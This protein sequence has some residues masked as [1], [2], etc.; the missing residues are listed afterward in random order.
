MLGKF[1]HLLVCSL[2]VLSSHFYCASAW[3]CAVIKCEILSFPSCH[4]LCSSQDSMLQLS[5]AVRLCALVKR[6]KCSFGSLQF[7]NSMAL[8]LSLI[9]V[10]PLWRGDFHYR[11]TLQRQLCTAITLCFFE[12]SQFM[13]LQLLYVCCRLCLFV[14][15]IQVFAKRCQ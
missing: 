6:H 15:W 1:A 3:I 8:E 4:K 12:L 11:Y 7:C 9:Y 10:F 2:S 13:K 5:W 14:D